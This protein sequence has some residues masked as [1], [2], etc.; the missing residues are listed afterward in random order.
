MLSCGI[1]T[2]LKDAL[3]LLPPFKSV[4][5]LIAP[6]PRVHADRSGWIECFLDLAYSVLHSLYSVSI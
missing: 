3:S 4:G 5:L 1:F 6:Y 2:A